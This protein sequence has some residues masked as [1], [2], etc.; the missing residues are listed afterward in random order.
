MRNY[1]PLFLL[2]TF[3]I[4]I[5][6]CERQPN[7]PVTAFVE[8]QIAHFDGV[9]VTVDSFNFS[10]YPRDNSSHPATGNVFITVLIRIHNS[11]NNTYE[12]SLQ[13]FQLRT[14]EGGRSGI[15]PLWPPRDEGRQPTLHEEALRPDGT[16]VRWVT[17]H[18]S[19]SLFPDALTWIPVTSS[20]L[21]IPF[22][23]DEPNV[24]SGRAVVFGKVTDSNNAAVSGARVEITPVF[25]HVDGN[26][27]FGNCHG[28]ARPAQ[29]SVTNQDGWYSDTIISSLSEP[30]C[31]DVKVSPPDNM[32]LESVRTGGDFVV[33]DERRPG[34]ELPEVRIDAVFPHSLQSLVNWN[35]IQEAF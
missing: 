14:I 33:P 31:M 12:V 26:E 10:W 23:P 22:P 2:I 19:Q 11:R 15:G 4:F 27:P 25:H 32:D 16:I 6:G 30:L 3:Y 5:I 9:T 7:A 24:R 18:V 20:V 13:S 1:G 35:H 29:L 21:D 28:H 34:Q 8:G 17:Y